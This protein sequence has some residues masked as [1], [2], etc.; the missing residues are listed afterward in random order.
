[1]KGLE[2]KVKLFL[3]KKQC[4]NKG[5]KNRYYYTVKIPVKIRIALAI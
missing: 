5:L 4:K 1:M 3:I 2:I